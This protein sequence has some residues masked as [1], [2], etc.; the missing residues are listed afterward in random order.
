MKCKE[1][2]SNASGSEHIATTK[3]GRHQLKAKCAVCGTTKNKFVSSSQAKSGEGIMDFITSNPNLING[4]IG[5]AQAAPALAGLAYG[6]K[7]LYDTAK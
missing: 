2:T 6:A 1:Q 5:L 4:A 7:K 3:N